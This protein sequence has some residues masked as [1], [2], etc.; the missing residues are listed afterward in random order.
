MPIYDAAIAEIVVSYRPGYRDGMMTR[1]ESMESRFCHLHI[2]LLPPRPTKVI[3][4]VLSLIQVATTHLPV[5]TIFPRLHYISP[6]FSPHRF[7]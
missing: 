2:S 5:Q 3:R 1:I 4:R 7:L 6:I